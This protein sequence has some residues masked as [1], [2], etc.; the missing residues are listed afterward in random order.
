MQLRRGPEEHQHGNWLLTGAS[1]RFPADLLTLGLAA[2]TTQHPIIKIQEESHRPTQGSRFLTTSRFNYQ[3]LKS[4]KKKMG[5][6]V[7]LT[8]LT[9]DLLF[10]QTVR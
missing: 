9:P 10:L 1:Q 3:W 7:S 4:E 5:P 8:V 2:T 6:L